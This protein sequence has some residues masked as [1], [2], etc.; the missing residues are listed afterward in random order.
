MLHQRDIINSIEEEFKKEVLGLTLYK[1]PGK[2]GKGI[3]R[4]PDGS[5]VSKIEE[6]RNSLE[7]SNRL[8]KAL[9]EIYQNVVGE[10]RIHDK[11]VI[12]LGRA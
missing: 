6:K 7:E 12:A 2:P 10:K 8:R 9:Y 11:D 5:S 3:V 1:T 4:N